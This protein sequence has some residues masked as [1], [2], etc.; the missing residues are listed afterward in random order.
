MKLMPVCSEKLRPLK[1]GMAAVQIALLILCLA[2]LQTAQAQL[3]TGTPGDA[4]RLTVSQNT[5]GSRT[6]YETD[7]LNKKA[8][9]TTTTRE[10]K[11]AGKM[12]YQLDDVG[13]YARGES[14]GADGKFQFKMEYKYDQAGRLAEELRL[15]KA[16]ALQMKLVYAYDNEGRP[17]GYSVYDAAGRLL[18]QTHPTGAPQGMDR[19]R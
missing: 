10:G 15:D 3:P 12:S 4:L 8:S 9:A 5:D 13:R 6:V 1:C 18:G 7:P 17:A 11:P 14:F 2:I 19:R 16:N